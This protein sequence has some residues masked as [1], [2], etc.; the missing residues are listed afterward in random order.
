MHI[1]VILVENYIT[2]LNIYEQENIH[3]FTKK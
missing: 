2:C 1:V 3:V